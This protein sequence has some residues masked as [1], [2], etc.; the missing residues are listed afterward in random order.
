MRTTKAVRSAARA[1]PYADTTMSKRWS[2]DEALACAGDGHRLKQAV[3]NDVVARNH[4]DFE[5]AR[6]GPGIGGLTG[7]AVCGTAGGS[8]EP[9]AAFIGQKRMCNRAY[10]AWS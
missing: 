1:R 6:S 3:I 8:G 7:A 4:T 10:T 2:R 9:P 5:G